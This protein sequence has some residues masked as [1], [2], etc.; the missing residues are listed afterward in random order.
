MSGGIVVVC[1][2]MAQYYKSSLVKLYT[3]GVYILLL[4]YLC[5]YNVMYYKNISLF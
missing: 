2:V 1:G 4:V 5:T 3:T